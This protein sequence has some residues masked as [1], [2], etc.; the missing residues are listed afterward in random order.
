MF[1]I[2]KSFPVVFEST[3]VWQ[4]TPK[5]IILKPQ[6]I[7]ISQLCRSKLQLWLSLKLSFKAS[8]RAV[9]LS[10][11]PLAGN[12]LPVLLTW[13]LVGFSSLWTVWIE[14]LNSSRAVDQRSP[15]IACYVELSTGQFKYGSWL[16]ER[17]CGGWEWCVCERERE[18]R[19]RQKLHSLS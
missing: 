19:L 8:A 12:L 18:K 14:G 11:A 1:I 6:I 7:I 4:I 2:L 9:V 17:V 13:L 10:D 15:S 3:I 16:N 5:F